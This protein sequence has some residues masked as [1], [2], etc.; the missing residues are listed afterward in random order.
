MLVDLPCSGDRYIF[1]RHRKGVCFVP[2]FESVTFN[3]IRRRS[4]RHIVINRILCA[5]RRCEAIRHISIIYIGYCMR[6]L[7]PAAGKGNI[8]SRHFEARDNCSIFFPAI[9]SP[10][11]KARHTCNCNLFTFVVFY[12]CRKRRSPIHRICI[13]VCY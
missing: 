12:C 1:S 13:L 7:R 4:R 11:I 5:F 9:E 8:L 10:S 2:A 3:R 6:I